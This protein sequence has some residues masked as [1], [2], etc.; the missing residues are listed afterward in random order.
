[1]DAPNFTHL[2]RPSPFS[3]FAVAPS[4]TFATSACRLSLNLFIA[5]ISQ[6]VTVAAHG[7]RTKTGAAMRDLGIISNAAVLCENGV[8]TWVGAMS[9]WHGTLP[10]HFS[11]IDASG[12]VVL[13]GFVDSH[14]HMMFAG[15][16]AHEFALRAQGASYQHIAEAGGGILSTIR[17][18]RAASKKD[19]KR[20]TRRYMNAMMQH[21]TTTVEI[22]SGY[23]LDVGSEIKML[24]AI[25]ELKDEEM[26]TV[27]PTFIG[28]HA[29]P[30]E[31]KDNKPAYVELIIE[32]MIPYV[33]RKNLATFCDVFCESGYFEPAASERILREARKFGMKLKVHADELTSLGGAELAARVGAVSADHL[34]HVSDGGIAALR[35]AGVVATLLPG[36]SFF[37]NHG[38]APAR[39]LIESGVAV[40][41]ASDFNPGS[42][43][44]FS[45]PLMMTI[46]CTQMRMTPEEALTAC[47]LNAA[48]ALD[49]SA[50]I[51][52]IEV[53][54][55]ADLLIAD[56]PDYRFLAYHFG[57]NHITTTIKNGT[58]LEF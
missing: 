35:E 8:I 37:L 41:I 43:M 18:V 38:Y 23:G 5:N 31:F 27:V 16:R 12:K 53:G 30:P 24:E 39:K 36:V 33:G 25:N 42:C 47:T 51:G 28:A 56:V 14:T 40:A 44:S 1:M 15:D 46:A 7:A 50:A 11:E 2:A 45:M 10:E 26:M 6:L 55:K 22:K 17:H 20:R 3:Y 13:P 21:G 52:S 48:A 29:Y 34:E 32:K 57:F 49:M 4:E 58:I 19:L 9:Q 54:K